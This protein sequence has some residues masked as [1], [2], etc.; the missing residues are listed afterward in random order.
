MKQGA[1]SFFR[2]DF[3]TTSFL[4]LNINLYFSPM[5]QDIRRTAIITLTI[6]FTI[7]LLGGLGWLLWQFRAVIAYLLIAAVLSLMGRPILKILGKVKIKSWVLPDYLKAGLTLVALFGAF[8]LIFMLTLP[9]LLN[10]TSKLQG[11]LSV[12]EISQSLAEPLAG[13]ENFLVRY[14]LIDLLKE[15]SGGENGNRTQQA[16]NRTEIVRYFLDNVL[17]VL[18]T[19]RISTVLNSIIGFT[20]DFLIGLFSITFIAFF[21]LKER[22]LLHGSVRTLTPQRFRQNMDHILASIKNL[23]TRYVIGVVL[24]VLLVGLLISLGLS[25]L[26]VENAFVIG[27]FAGLFN[28]IP[29][30]GPIIG[31]LLGVSLAIIGALDLDFYSQMIPLILKVM[32]VFIVVQLID[33]FVFQPMIYSSSV[34]A[35]PLEI[36]IVIL[37]AGSLAGVGGMILAIP[38]YTILRVIAREFFNKFEAVQ[39]ITRHMD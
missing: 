19:A 18:D 9:P 17:S 1:I 31:G 7:L 4:K 14:D 5:N 15:E 37:S 21:F 35:H 25:L 26:G 8:T 13:L 39:A 10:Q 22:S 12:E 6:V 3:P 20:G 29:Y 2:A 27:F 34:K 30:L 24:E 23:L 36:F 16:D 11:A 33:N 28:V 32:V 38:T